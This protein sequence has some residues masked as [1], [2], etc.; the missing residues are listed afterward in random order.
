MTDLPPKSPREALVTTVVVAVLVYALCRYLLGASTGE[1]AAVVV[2]FTLLTTA[3]DL[4]RGRYGR[5][6]E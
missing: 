5:R 3:L 6:S 2:V 1:S 4:V